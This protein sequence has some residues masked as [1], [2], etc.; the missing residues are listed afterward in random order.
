[1]GELTTEVSGQPRP[2]TG[3]E[4]G[5]TNQYIAMHMACVGGDGI[6]AIVSQFPDS[7]II[8]PPITVNTSPYALG[9]SIGGKITLTNVARNVGKGG[10]LQSITVIDRSGTQQPALQIILFDSDPTSATIT[11]KS[12][13]VFS[14]DITKVIAQI[15]ILASDY[16]LIGNNFI[17]NKNLESIVL[18]TNG[19]ANLYMAIIAQGATDF[20][21][22]TDLIVKFGILRD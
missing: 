22:S 10:V 1:M 9:N 8:V 2:V 14:T 15:P 18:Q 13:F 7:V 5:D 20:V 17:V 4:A 6:D 3:E 12:A 11:D 19:S 16:T 21:A